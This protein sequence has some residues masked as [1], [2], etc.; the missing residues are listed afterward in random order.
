MDL[1]KFSKSLSFLIFCWLFCSSAANGQGVGH[2]QRFDLTDSLRL[3]EGQFAELFVPDY[4]HTPQN[5]KI[6]LVFNLHSANWAAENIVYRAR[7][8]AILFN[9]HLGLLSSPYRKYFRDASKFQTILNKITQVLDS[10]KTVRNPHIDR[11]VIS[12]FSAGYAG[13]REMLKSSEYYQKIDAILLADGLHTNSEKPIM[14]R[15]M[16]NFLRFAK[17]ARDKRKILLITHSCIPTPGYEST[18]STANY[19]IHG[20]GADREAYLDSNEVGIQYSRVDAGYFHLKGYFGEHGKDHLKHLY[21]LHL[22]LEQAMEMLI[23]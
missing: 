10:Q 5:G 22:L 6:T 1:N 8:N 2:G 14:E 12:S 15:Q 16:A 19:L 3:S 9:I 17:D 7:A 18:T 23:Q 4:Y 21:G 20:I 13:V 11:L